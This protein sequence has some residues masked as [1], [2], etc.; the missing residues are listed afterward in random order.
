MPRSPTRGTTLSGWH[1]KTSSPA[2]ERLA[3]PPPATGGHFQF[4]TWARQPDLHLAP[5]SD[6]QLACGL[7]QVCGTW[8]F[9]ANSICVVQ[10]RDVPGPSPHK[11]KTSFLQPRNAEAPT[12][13][14]VDRERQQG[15]R[16]PARAFSSISGGDKKDWS[17]DKSAVR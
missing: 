7:L 6:S 2:G 17:C 14:G 10:P 13:Q 3:L 8:L 5:T 11:H 4:Y 16:K 15:E 12:W 9:Q 1:I